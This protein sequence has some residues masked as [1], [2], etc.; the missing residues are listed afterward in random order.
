MSTLSTHACLAR[1]ENEAASIE[2]PLQRCRE[3]GE[4]VVASH[5]HGTNCESRA[6]GGHDPL[7]EWA[8]SIAGIIAARL[9]RRSG[10]L[11]FTRSDGAPGGGPDNFRL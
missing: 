2:S 4:F 10:S 9:T 8:R 3:E 6:R 1:D 5:L 7:G 11:R